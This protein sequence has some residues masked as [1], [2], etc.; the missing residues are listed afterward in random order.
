MA[1]GRKR[2]GTFGSRR[3]RRAAPVAIPEVIVPPASAPAAVAAPVAVAAPSA[4]A[5]RT[6]KRYPCRKARRRVVRNNK[7]IKILRAQMMRKYKHVKKVRASHA[8]C[9]RKH[10]ISKPSFTRR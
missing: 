6:K 5:R 4:P 10:N 8:A 1:K 7:E 2:T 9:R 3:R